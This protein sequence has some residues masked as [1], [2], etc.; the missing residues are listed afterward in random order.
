MVTKGSTIEM[1]IGKY[2]L[3][4]WPRDQRFKKRFYSFTVHAFQ[5]TAV[6][7]VCINRMWGPLPRNTK[8]SSNFICNPH[9]LFYLRKH[10]FLIKTSSILSVEKPCRFWIT[11]SIPRTFHR[12]LMKLLQLQSCTNKGILYSYSRRSN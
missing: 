9:N 4:T 5:N 3:L 7:R 2:V 11:L 8:I 12:D 10:I 6:A 1:K